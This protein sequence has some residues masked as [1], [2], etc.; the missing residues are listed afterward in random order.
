MCVPV[1]KDNSYVV[2]AVDDAVGDAEVQEQVS[3]LLSECL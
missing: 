2:A 1:C 3:S